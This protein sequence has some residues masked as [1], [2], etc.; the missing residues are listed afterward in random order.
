MN[1]M[2]QN[3]SKN[4]MQNSNT[5]KPALNPEKEHHG[6]IWMHPYML[7][8]VLTIVLFIFLLFMGWV[9]F[10]NGWIPNRGTTS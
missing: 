9:A 8:I 1:K 7:Y 4:P 10:T 6:S 2:S 3:D 5:N